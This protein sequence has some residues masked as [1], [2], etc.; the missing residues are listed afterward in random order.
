MKRAWLSFSSSLGVVPEE[1]SE[2]NPDSAPQA[3][4]MNKKGNSEPAKAGP[5]L[6]KANS[7]TAGSCA[8]GRAI[9]MPMASMAMVP[10]FMNVDR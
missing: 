4:V 2:W 8:I 6:L 3:M 10:T 1:I 7:L 5:A 9:R